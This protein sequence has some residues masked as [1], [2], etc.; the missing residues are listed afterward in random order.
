[1]F[2]FAVFDGRKRGSDS[3]KVPAI[4]TH[5]LVRKW[6]SSSD[7]LVATT[8]TTTSST[9]GGRAA[10]AVVRF[11]INIRSALV[12]ILHNR[13]KIETKKWLVTL[14]YSRMEKTNGTMSAST[15]SS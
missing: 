8:T 2:F 11:I 12:H 7:R 10:A 4:E 1:V 5:A 9:G 13:L 15:V 14:P 3:R 6:H